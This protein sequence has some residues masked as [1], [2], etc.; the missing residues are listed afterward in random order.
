MNGAQD[1]NELDL[2]KFEMEAKNREY[3][4]DHPVVFK[5]PTFEAKR[6]KAIFDPDNPPPIIPKKAR[7]II[8]QNDF[9]QMGRIII[10]DK[11]QQK[12]TTGVVVAIGPDVEEGL[13]RLGEMIVFSQY[14]GVPLNILD[15][16]GDEHAF[17]SLTPDE[18]AG[19][20]VIDPTK[21]VRK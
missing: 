20:L 13:V 18:I 10:P 7:I 2:L 6:K 17:L 5:E 9:V 1:P 3:L 15:E 21:V 16:K 8:T 12:P 19:E 11:A 14:G 4:A